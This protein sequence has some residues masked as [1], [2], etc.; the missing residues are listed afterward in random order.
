MKTTQLIGTSGKYLHN[1]DFEGVGCIKTATKN[2]AGHGINLYKKGMAIL[3][4]WS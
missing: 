2:V 3:F 1:C 4:A